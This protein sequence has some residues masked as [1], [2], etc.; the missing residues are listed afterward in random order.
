M[1]ASNLLQGF[2]RI[3]NRA[4]GLEE[5]YLLSAGGEILNPQQRDR[6]SPLFAQRFP[7]S[8]PLIKRRAQGSEKHQGSLWLFR[9]LQPLHNSWSD[10]GAPG[11]SGKADAAATNATP[12]AGGNPSPRER[13]NPQTPYHWIAVVR[14][15]PAS[16]LRTSGFHNAAGQVALGLLGLL[17]AVSL[18]RA[19][20]DE[21]LERLRQQQRSADLRF[22]QILHQA[23]VGMAILAVDGTILDAND[24]LGTLLDTSAAALVGRCW[25][26]CTA[27][28]E[29]RAQE[30]T[31][32]QTVLEQG[33]SHQAASHTQTFLTGSGEERWGTR[34]MALLPA[35]Q[36]VIVQVAD[37]SSLVAAHRHLQTAAAA[38]IVGT[39]DWDIPRN[40]LSW[41]A[42]M[43]SLYGRP[44]LEGRL[45]YADWAA[46]LHADDRAR[47]EQALQRA[48]QGLERYHVRFRVQHPDGA[49]RHLQA[50]GDTERGPSGEP[51][52]MVG[53]NYDITA[54]VEQEEALDS[55]RRLL[56]VT[57]DTMVDPHV[58]LEAVRRAD[59]RLLDFRFAQVNQAA[60]DQLGQ[61]RSRLLGRRLHSWQPPLALAG[62]SPLL[63]R[64]LEQ[65]RHLV[66]DA[67]PLAAPPAPRRS[68]G[69]C[70]RCAW[71][72]ASASAGAMPASA[73]ATPGAWPL[74]KRSSG[75]CCKTPVT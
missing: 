63:Q 39:W 48:L 22:Q 44:G 23:P 33:C 46:A 51:R 3:T 74:L 10:A 18:G 25:L 32:L 72:T 34:T 47:V 59:G 55:Q 4:R 45:R 14:V 8:W 43:A 13:S 61:S 60:C 37:S 75:C 2:D 26:D 49:V 66:V 27:G 36:Q 16:L 35:E 54:L 58:H 53:V 57:L 7:G 21:R 68:T 38:G 42:V 24:A 67:L 5:G 69:T 28:G 20:Y 40:Q 56:A 11:A 52:R 62:L 31:L 9:R 73:K 65:N 64:A 6:G 1:D 70:A 30:A 19:L 12:A 50:M 41:D 29:A 71:K 17:L 15:P